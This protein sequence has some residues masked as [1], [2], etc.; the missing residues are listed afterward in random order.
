MKRLFGL[1]LG[2]A[3]LISP[4]VHGQVFTPG[5]AKDHVG[6]SATVCGSIAS[7]NTA[8]G[9]KGKPTFLNLDKP[10]PHQIFTILVWESDR[11]AVGPIPKTG[12]V[13]AKGTISLYHGVPEIVAHSSA[14]LFLPTLSNDRH[15]TNS[16]GQTVHSPAY[17]NGGPPAG[18]T[19][20][21]RDGTYGFSQH[22]QG[23]CSRHGG[24]AKWL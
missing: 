13:C 11:A 16:D 1:V 7:E 4:V 18:A 20:L 24:V 22:R 21:C 9:S 8:D 2:I 10:Y 5:E 17:S 6:E 19:A 14:E 15:Y 3:A 23:T 12:A